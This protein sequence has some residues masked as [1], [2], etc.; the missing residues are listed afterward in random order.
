MPT[1]ILPDTL[2][3]TIFVLGVLMM[4]LAGAMEQ[5][6]GKAQVDA[7]QCAMNIEVE[8]GNHG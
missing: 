4:T 5:M 7:S 3:K 2:R 1:G 6:D 8:I